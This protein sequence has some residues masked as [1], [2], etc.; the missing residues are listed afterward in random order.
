MCPWPAS[1]DSYV[2]LG[3]ICQCCQPRDSGLQSSGPPIRLAEFQEI[4]TSENNLNGGW[5]LVKDKYPPSSMQ[6]GQL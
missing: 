4:S 1:G 5:W 3:D 6:V 2:C